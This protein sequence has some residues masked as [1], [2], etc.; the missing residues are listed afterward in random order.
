M[1]NEIEL[2]IVIS[3]IVTSI[4]FFGIKLINEKFPWI[5]SECSFNEKSSVFH[6]KMLR[7]LGIIYPIS[8]L[9]IVF[10]D[11]GLIN[12]CDYVLLF[13]L[14]LLGFIDD[15]YNINYKIKIV[16]FILIS[17]IYNYYITFNFDD[18]IT[19]NLIIKILFFVFLIIFFNQ[20]DGINGLAILTFII[21]FIFM[22][23]LKD[24]FINYLPIIFIFIPYLYFNLKG[25]IGIQGDSGSYFLAGIF[26]INLDFET[27]NYS[28][29]ISL[30]ML[31]P[32]LLDLIATTLVKIY[33]KENISKGHKDNLYQIFASYKNNH[34]SST[35]TFTVFQILTCTF[36]YYLYRIF[37]LKLFITLIML[38]LIFN[39]F[40]F[41]I[42][43]FKLNKDKLYKN[44]DYK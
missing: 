11:N 9:P 3:F 34:I 23:L 10:F 24:A 38:V 22:L 33:F 43:S 42:L 37:D 32:I 6:K 35:I 30:F 39:F 1:N 7:G 17:S 5:V 20:I 44:Y 29:L 13:S 8:I 14:V 36:V 31:C 19:F 40:F 12:F 28:Y 41:L 21:S 2:S 15:K 16:S 18:F 25:E 27:N 4:T 26:F